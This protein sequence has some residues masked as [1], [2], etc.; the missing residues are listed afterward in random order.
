MFW[1]AGQCSS[2]TREMQDRSSLCPLAPGSTEGLKPLFPCRLTRLWKITCYSHRWLSAPGR[3]HSRQKVPLLFPWRCLSGPLSVWEAGRT[4]AAIVSP[5]LGHAAEASAAG[6]LLPAI[7]V[8]S[9]GRLVILVLLQRTHAGRGRATHTG[10]L[11]QALCPWMSPFY[12]WASVSLCVQRGA[13]G[14]Q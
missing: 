8:G 9:L 6:S 11:G 12:L 5:G 3:C 4:P 1:G 2:G 10:C 7:I 13:K 14:P